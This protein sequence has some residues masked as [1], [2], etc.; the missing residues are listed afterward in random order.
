LVK[1][2]L[3]K[4]LLEEL[5]FAAFEPEPPKREGDAQPGEPDQPIS[6]TDCRPG[7]THADP[8]SAIGVG[9]VVLAFDDK[10]TESWFEAVVVAV[11]RDGDSLSL[12]WRDWPDLRKFSRQR[13]KVGLV[14]PDA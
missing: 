2:E 11:S 7:Q 1:P 5:D 10:D 13:R 3:C 9:S 14:A 8:W 6:A 12:R 4:D